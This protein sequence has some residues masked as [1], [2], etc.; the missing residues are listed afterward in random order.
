MPWVRAPASSVRPSDAP[1]ANYEP[2]AADRD[3]RPAKRDSRPAK[4]G[5]RGQP[6]LTALQAAATAAY[7][8]LV[9]P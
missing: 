6:T 2:R 5:A 7:S 1:A 3:S 8:G 4:R 9:A